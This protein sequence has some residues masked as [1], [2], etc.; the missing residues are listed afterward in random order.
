MPMK[1]SIVRKLF[2]KNAALKIMDFSVKSFYVFL[3]T[4]FKAKLFSENIALK[5]FD[6]VV[7]NF[8]VSLDVIFRF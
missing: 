4:I 1:M 5:I 3:E 7:N 8:N 6:I 2:S